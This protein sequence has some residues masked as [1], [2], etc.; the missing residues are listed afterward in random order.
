MALGSQKSNV[1][2][3][4]NITGLVHEIFVG[5]VLPSVRWESVTAQLFGAAGEGDYR[6]DGESLN[7][8]TDLLRPHGAL[9]TD[10]E[11]PDHSHVDAANWQTTPVR[12]Y[13]RRAVDNFTE[14]AAVKGPGSF[15]DFGTRVFDQLWGAFRMMEIRHAV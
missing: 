10:G 9:G 7:G 13:V 4:S 5:D 14:A 1:Q 12:R 11:L 3:L 6:Y 8:A 2:A 15:A